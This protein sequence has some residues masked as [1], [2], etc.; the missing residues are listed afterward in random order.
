MFP[1]TSTPIIARIYQKQNT[2]NTPFETSPITAMNPY[3]FYS[4]FNR[5]ALSIKIDIL[6]S[7]TMLAGTRLRT[8]P[9]EMR[10]TRL[11]SVLPR[12]K[13]NGF[14][15]G[16]WRFDL[17]SVIVRNLFSAPKVRHDEANSQTCSQRQDHSYE[18]ST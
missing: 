5:Y 15:F 13:L 16:Y 4:A 11:K 18:H 6:S 1:E 14:G 7:C 10:V 2:S 9:Q 12:Y 17:S 8:I 3:L